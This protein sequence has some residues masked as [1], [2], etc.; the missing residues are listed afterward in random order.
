MPKIKLMWRFLGT[1]LF[2]ATLLCI[3]C[4]AHAAEC[5]PSEAVEAYESGKAY[6]ESGRLDKGISEL[7]RAVAIYPDFG[8]AWY[9]LYDSYKRAERPDDEIRALEQL[10][11]INPGVYS[12]A[13]IWREVLALHR[14]EANIPSA[15]VDALNQC[16]HLTAGSKRAIAAC[17]RALSLHANYVDAHY[18]LGV[19]YVYAGDEE[20]AKEQ[21]AA[22]IMLDRTMAG[23]LAHAMDELTGWMTEDYK[24][25]LQ[26]MFASTKVQPMPEAPVEP[27]PAEFSDQEVA[28]ILGTYERQTE[29]LQNLMAD[30]RSVPKE[31]KFSPPTEFRDQLKQQLVPLT[32]RYVEVEKA[33]CRGATDWLFEAPD[34]GGRHRGISEVV[35]IAQNLGIGDPDRERWRVGL[36]Q[37]WVAEKYC[38]AECTAMLEF[39]IDRESDGQPVTFHAWLGVVEDIADIVQCASSSY[40]EIPGA[41]DW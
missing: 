29:A 10:I 22:L 4:L 36:Y 26:S 33:V 41:E 24:Q 37:E 3:A 25:E 40:G 23:M 1:S 7:E 20:S 16:R 34:Y 11:R 15:A 2:A 18:F 31:C 6:L 5:A 21:L 14:S 38:K 19:N 39:R 35:K 27:L 17:K 12:G 28:R 8:T 30:P 13:E 32:F 9:E